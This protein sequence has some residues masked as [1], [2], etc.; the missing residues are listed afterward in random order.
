MGCRACGQHQLPPCRRACSPP[1]PAV[2][3]RMPAKPVDTPVPVPAVASS[4]SAS[5][6]SCTCTARLE[7]DKHKGS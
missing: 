1:L 4:A 2:G 6:R 3:I 5:G 7:K